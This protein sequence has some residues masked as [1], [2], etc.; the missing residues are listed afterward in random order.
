MLCDQCVKIRELSYMAI[1]HGKLLL[2]I[3]YIYNF[4]SSASKKIS[5]SLA[6]TAQTIKKSVEEGKLDGIIDKVNSN[7]IF[8]IYHHYI[9]KKYELNVFFPQTILGDFQ[10]EQEKFVQEKNSKKTGELQIYLFFIIKHTAVIVI[11]YT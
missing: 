3:G 8:L 6:E 5:E 7:N 10:K 2:S 9:F 4:A 1:T 11:L